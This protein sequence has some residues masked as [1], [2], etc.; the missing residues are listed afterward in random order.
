MKKLNL[1][2]LFDID[3]TLIKTGGAGKNAMEDAFNLL[4]HK[5]NGMEKISF[6]GSTDLGIFDHSLKLNGISPEQAIPESVFREKYLSLLKKYLKENPEGQELLPG[7]ADFLAHCKERDDIYMGLVTGNY[8]EGA[9]IKLAHFNIEHYF[10][11]GA[12]GCDFANR[13]LLPPLAIQRIQQKGYTLPPKNKI[14]IIGD[15][16]KDIECAKTNGLPSLIT[17][18]GFSP[19]EDILRDKPEMTMETLENFPMFLKH[20]LT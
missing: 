17:F 14:W 2:L 7:V 12:F 10:N 15:T 8:R 11:E 1:V 4:F 20:V 9:Q 6:A 19:R 3:G 5:Q 18:T 16:I 13:N